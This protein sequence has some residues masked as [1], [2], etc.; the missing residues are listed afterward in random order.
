MERL[1]FGV[2]VFLYGPIELENLEGMLKCSKASFCNFWVFRGNFAILFTRH[3][4]NY[5]SW[6]PKKKRLNDIPKERLR[7]FKEREVRWCY[8]GVNVGSEMMGKN[9]NFTR[10]VL[11][12]KKYNNNLFLGVMLTSSD[13]SEYAYKISKDGEKTSKVSLSSLRTF[14][15]RR[16]CPGAPQKVIPEFMFKEIIS[17]IKG[18][19]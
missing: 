4:K 15:A 7:S 1:F 14:D 12:T 9:D 2:A 17:E 16:L 19:V 11:I 13:R 8:I 10:P 6:L 3:L 5:T 18:T